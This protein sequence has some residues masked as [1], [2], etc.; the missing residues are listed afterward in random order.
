MSLRPLIVGAL[1]AL[2]VCCAAA[3]PTKEELISELRKLRKAL[4]QFKY[5]G[6][7]T[8]VA[9]AIDQALPKL[10]DIPDG[11][12]LSL[13]AQKTVLIPQNE[14]LGPA[15]LGGLIRSGGSGA[16]A[17]EFADTGLINVLDGYFTFDEI[18]RGTTFPTMLGAR[19]LRKYFVPLVMR[20]GS[21]Y[22]LGQ[23]KNGL[24]WSQI[25]NP[26]IYRGKYF[27]AHGVD[28]LQQP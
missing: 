4:T 10:N 7:Y 16:K 13:I 27:V 1:L 21:P 3:Q 14:A 9:T 24:S 5:L 15:G 20:K 8:L 11:E 17:L 23:S 18:K 6:R 26:G 25:V 22:A 28:A 12:D 2:L 19:R